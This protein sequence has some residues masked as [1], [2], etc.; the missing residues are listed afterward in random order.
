MSTRTEDND[1]LIV[2]GATIIVCLVWG[3]AT[4]MFGH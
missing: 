4:V 2:V 3:F 1:A